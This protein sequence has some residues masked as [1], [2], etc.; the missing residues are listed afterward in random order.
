MPNLHDEAAKQAAHHA[1]NQAADQAAR[2]AQSSGE[3]EDFLAKWRGRWPEWRIAQTFVDPAQ[4]L[5]AEA[6]FALL[7]EF[8]DAA[9]SGGDPTPGIAKLGWWQEELRG[10]AKGARRHPLGLVLHK[11][12]APWPSLAIG[13]SAMPGV[14]ERL[15]AVD[16]TSLDATI[17]LDALAEALRPCTE[18][19]EAC[20]HVL[21]GLATAHAA[22]AADGHR[23]RNGKALLGWQVLW[24]STETSEPGRHRARAEALLAAWPAQASTRP[25]RVYEAL[26]RR[27]LQGV[28]GG[29][30][31]VP[32]SPWTALWSSWRAARA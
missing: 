9:W 21:F 30:T 27:R 5:R 16:A 4:R 23:A 10:W 8:T 14:R 17:T 32:L 1:A 11:I 26:I 12:P 20:E 13:L 6:W 18:A 3:V 29:G 2:Q 19:I 22:G 28:A 7:Q 15:H 31:L 24:A 25:Q